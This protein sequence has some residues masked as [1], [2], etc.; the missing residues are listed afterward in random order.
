[1]LNILRHFV[2]ISGPKTRTAATFI[3]CLG[4]SHP[5]ADTVLSVITKQLQ[6]TSPSITLT[7]W[8]YH[9]RVCPNDILDPND[10]L[11]LRASIVSSDANGTKMNTDMN[12][13]NSI[14]SIV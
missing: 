1:M 9:L 8:P 7:N 13:P 11:S 12:W 6:C 5:T 2:H 10:V 4:T 14:E 3:R